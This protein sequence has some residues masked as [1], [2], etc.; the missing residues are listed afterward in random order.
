MKKSHRKDVIMARIIFAAICLVLICV[1]SVIVM[2][3]STKNAQKAQE[4]NETQ[5]LV[6]NLP[7]EEPNP[8]L[9]PVTQ[10]TEQP[11]EPVTEQTGEG[12]YERT[13]WTNSGVNLRSEPNTTCPVITILLKGTRLEIIGE[14]GKGDWL[15]VSYNGT[16]GY[17]SKDYITD[18]DPY[19]GERP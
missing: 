19:T 2:F 5:P 10:M 14:A 8:D 11:L 13:V 12:L 7:P 4:N 15:K 9:P 3:V 16:Q 18:K 1:I 17:V 6:A